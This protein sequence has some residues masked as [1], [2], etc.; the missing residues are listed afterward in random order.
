VNIRVITLTQDQIDLLSREVNRLYTLSEPALREHF[1]DL[2]CVYMAQYM[3]LSRSTANE[4]SILTRQ[5]GTFATQPTHLLKADC[6]LNLQRA[7]LFQFNLLEE[8]KKK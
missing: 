1:M 4:L 7:I 2:V 5:S 8:R 6:A 3:E